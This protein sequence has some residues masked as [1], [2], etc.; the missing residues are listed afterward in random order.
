MA[1]HPANAAENP[2]M[3]DSHH[4]YP[5]WYELTTPDPD[6]AGAFYARLLGWSI[7]KAPMEGMEYYL[8][9]LGGTMV[10][11]MMAPSMPGI[12]PN[13]CLYFA[14]TDCDATVAAMLAD[15]AQQYVAPSDIPGTGRFAILADP[16]GAVFGLLQ[17]APGGE[18]GAFDQNKRGHGNWHE[19]MSSDPVAALAFYGKHLGWK[20]STAMDMGEMGTYQ[21]VALAVGD[22]GGLMGKPSADMPSAWLPYF[23]VAS[24]DAA[25]TA[26]TEGGGRVMNGPMEVPGGAYIVQATD[27]QGAWV[28]VT[29]PR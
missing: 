25:V 2:P 8:G 7:D 26:I 9:T 21:L 11:G 5:C 28:A 15:G 19:L 14:V 29:G 24:I 22:F 27:P 12:P 17:P 23:G 13:W 4:G 3:T 6:A 16:Q 1:I 20:T 18:G 10:A